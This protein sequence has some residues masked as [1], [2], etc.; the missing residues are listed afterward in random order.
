MNHSI[1][2]VWLLVVAVAG[3]AS[4][5]GRSSE[6]AQ[7]QAPIVE[8]VGCL[9]Q[10]GADWMLTNATDAVVS[11]TAYTTPEAVKAA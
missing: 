10:K 1:S 5:Q 8:A 11:M 3:S 6:P 2:I 7:D 4:G 9:S